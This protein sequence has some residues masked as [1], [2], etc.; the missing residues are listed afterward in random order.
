[1]TS[2]KFKP[3]KYYFL[4]HDLNNSYKLILIDRTGQCAYTVKTHTLNDKFNI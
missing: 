2:D 4:M 1:M 3:A